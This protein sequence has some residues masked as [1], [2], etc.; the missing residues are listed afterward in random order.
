MRGVKKGASPGNVS[1]AGQAR[2]SLTKAA[3][4]FKASLAAA[5]HRSDHAR[6]CFDALDKASLREVL[7]RDQRYACVY[8]ERQLNEGPET[9]IEHWHPLN[10]QPQHALEWKNLYLSC[11]TK[12]TCD[13]AKHGRE[14]A[15]SDTHPAL[16]WPS[17]KPYETC[18]G[19]TSDGRMYVR[20]D[21]PLTADERRALEYAIRE[22]P[23]AGEQ[24]PAALNLNDR[25]LVAARIAALDR[26]RDSLRRDFPQQHASPADRE[27]RAMAHL[28]GA[29]Y[30]AFVSVCVAWLRSELGQGRPA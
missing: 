23:R 28:G 14:L 21:A 1:P 11:G 22:A 10:R 29:R 20:T 15:W 2:C 3:R 30:P 9:P 16:P 13:D 6:S 4:N 18:V 27:A 12:R 26:E 19:F 24:G 5:A 25:V 7:A 8:C 17:A